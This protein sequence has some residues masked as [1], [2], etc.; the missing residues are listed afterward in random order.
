MA[1]AETRTPA[2]AFTRGISQTYCRGVFIAAFGTAWLGTHGDLL[3]G[4]CHSLIVMC[5]VISPPD[6]QGAT[7]PQSRY[8]PLHIQLV[9]MVGSLIPTY[10]PARSR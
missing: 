2:V 10:N 8:V 6:Y 3:L 4:N 7:M 5:C 1:Y 9:Q